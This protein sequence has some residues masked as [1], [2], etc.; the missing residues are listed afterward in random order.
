MCGKMLES[1]FFVPMFISVYEKRELKEKPEMH[2]LNHVMGSRSIVTL[3]K[4]Q[5]EAEGKK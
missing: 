4:L 3:D 5:M 1:K 2:W